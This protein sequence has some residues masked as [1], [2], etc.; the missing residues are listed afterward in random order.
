MHFQRRGHAWEACSIQSCQIWL[1][2]PLAQVN[3]SLA[4]KVLAEQ[5]GGGEPGE[6]EQDAP[7]GRRQKRP[8]ADLL[9]DERFA[10]LFEDRAF[11]IDE[12]SEEYRALHP[13]AGAAA[14]TRSLIPAASLGCKC[15]ALRCS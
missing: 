2:K 12:K 11:A 6:P 8:A 13:N 5:G 15:H 10:A 3:A 1:C 9:Q 4:A 7:G 14:R